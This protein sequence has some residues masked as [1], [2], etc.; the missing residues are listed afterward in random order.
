MKRIDVKQGS[1][2]WHEARYRKIGGSTAKGLLTP[3]DTLLL[4]LVAEFSE[5][6]ELN[7]GY[8]SE[9]MVRGT[10]LEP[11]AREELNKATA[12]L[13]VDIGWLQCEEIPLLGISPDGITDDDRFSCEIKCPAAK[14]HT[15]TILSNEIPLDNIHQCVHYFVVNPKLEKHYFVSFRPENNYRPF[16]MKELTRDSLVNLGTKAKPVIKPIWEW[17]LVYKANAMELQGRIDSE[18]EKLRF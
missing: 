13:F 6:F 8:Q 10:E 17:V 3:T 4:E 2:E 18:L 15:E 5:D 12:L 9:D 7:E 1:I 11:Y 14:R 16:F